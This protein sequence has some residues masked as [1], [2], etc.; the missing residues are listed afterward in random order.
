MS[1]NV[2]ATVIGLVG[3]M[4]LTGCGASQVNLAMQ[5]KVNDVD[6][7]RVT[8]EQIKD[9]KFEQPSEE[10]P[11]VTENQSATVISVVF[12]QRVDNIDA[13]GN[14]IA[15]ITV[16][17][18]QYTVTEK[19]ATKFDFDSAREADKSKPLAKLVGATYKINISPDG[20]V[21]VLEAQQAR[22][23]LTGATTDAKVASNLFKDD[24]IIQRHEVLALP[25]GVQSTV[26]V[27][28]AWS[29]VVASPPG[30]LAPKSYEKVYTLK[31]I[32]GGKES[33]TAQVVMT[34]QESAVQAEGVAK[35]A[36]GM[37]FMAKMFDTEESYNGSMK[38]HLGSGKVSEY[39]EKLAVRYIAAESPAN[40]KPDKGPDTLIMGLT[41]TVSGQMLTQ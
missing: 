15:D 13:K 4:I 6:T 41:Y 20:R 18:L 11:K 37:G 9:Y 1:R 22:K 27:G 25:K 19:D 34:A 8:T 23:L 12:D 10:P 7:Y 38:F 29:E 36:P 17:G 28:S 31:E 33:G 40:Q 24:T 32:E 2:I 21:S 35:D 30:L 26:K 14:A 39:M 5:F 16:K 3:V